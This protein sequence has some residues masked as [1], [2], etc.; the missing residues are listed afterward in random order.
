MDEPKDKTPGVIAPPPLIYLGFLVVG[1]VLDHFWPV[2][3]LPGSWRGPLSILLIAVGLVLAILGL[4]EFKRV[5]TEV[6]PHRP[7]KALATGGI[8]AYTRNPLYLAITLVYLGIAAA[9]DDLWLLSLAVPL[10]IVIR[11][12][13]IAREER[14]LRVRF[15][16]EYRQ[17]QERV[18]R[19]V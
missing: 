6:S 5:E 15:G 17:Y 19:W 18:R 8:Y 7:S 4:H 13:V 16:E 1:L 12:G 2:G 11:Y 9:T 10:L 14:Y 3:F